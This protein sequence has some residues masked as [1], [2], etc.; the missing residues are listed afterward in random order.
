MVVDQI[1][2]DADVCFYKV[3]DYQVPTF[4]RWINS[5]SFLFCTGR[6]E[7]NTLEIRN[8]LYLEKRRIIRI[9]TVLHCVFNDECGEFSCT[10]LSASFIYLFNVTSVIV[11]CYDVVDWSRCFCLVE[12]NLFCIV[13]SFQLSADIERVLLSESREK[14]LCMWIWPVCLLWKS[15][16]SILLVGLLALW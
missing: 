3:V 11:L 5:R 14:K 4:K 16:N 1:K 15:V 12:N 6:I 2:T 13:N 9:W 8:I 10:V 7:R